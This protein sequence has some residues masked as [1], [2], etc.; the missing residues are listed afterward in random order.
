MDE[1]DK[2]QWIKRLLMKILAY[3]YINIYIYPEINTCDCERDFTYTNELRR[4]PSS[5]ERTLLHT[6]IY[7]HCHFYVRPRDSRKTI[8]IYGKQKQPIILRT[9]AIKFYFFWLLIPLFFWLHWFTPKIPFSFLFSG[10]RLNYDPSCSNLT[11]NLC[12]LFLLFT[13]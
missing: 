8:E 9:V 5:H 13:P 3:L 1:N 10:L 2:W 12:R 6:N 4:N 7:R 11:S